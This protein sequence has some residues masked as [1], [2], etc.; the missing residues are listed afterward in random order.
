M[1]GVP[2]V[3]L[4]P[5]SADEH[6]QTMWRI[7]GETFA[8]VRVNIGLVQTHQKKVHDV[9][10]YWH[11]YNRGDLGPYSR[12]G[13]CPKLGIGLGT[14]FLYPGMG[15]NAIVKRGYMP[16]IGHTPPQKVVQG[17]PHLGHISFLRNSFDQSASLLQPQGIGHMSS[18]PIC[19]ELVTTGDPL[20]DTMTIC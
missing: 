17:Y 9:K 4:S 12:K 7:L 19:I 13:I 11:R 15:L 3:T 14:T 20:S 18:P 10:V 5:H 6:M 8:E 16:Q 2:Q 1:L